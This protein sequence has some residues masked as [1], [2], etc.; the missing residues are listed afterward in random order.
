MSTSE[1]KI[2]VISQT[3]TSLK[4]G[5]MKKSEL[6]E[7]DEEK[8]DL[9]NLDI[10]FKIDNLTDKSSIKLHTIKMKAMLK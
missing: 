6:E 5:N 3:R 8:L 7:N 9:N 2:N 10:H 1:K 4:E